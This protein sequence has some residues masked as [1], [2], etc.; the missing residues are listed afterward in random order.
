MS[1]TKEELIEQIKEWIHIDNEL[2]ELQRAAKERRERKKELT[3]QLVEIMRDNESDCFDMSEGKL[4]YTQTRVKSPIN[5]KFLLQTL[6]KFYQGSSEKAGEMTEFILSNR[7]E[8]IK[9]NIR[10]KIKK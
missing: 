3:N 8:K 1:L 2:R 6:E 10:R 9:E 5:K 7:T 4:V